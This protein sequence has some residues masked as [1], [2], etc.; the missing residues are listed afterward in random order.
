MLHGESVSKYEELVRDQARK[1]IDAW[2]S[3]KPFPLFPY[4]QS[5]ALEV[6]LHAVVYLDDERDRNELRSLIP[7]ILD[8]GALTELVWIAPWLGRVGPWKRYMETL[9]RTDDL[10]FK[11]I[12]RRR[13]D[14][15]LER[16]EDI[17]SL[18]IRSGEDEARDDRWLR[19]QLM[20]LILAG[21]DTTAS[22]LAWT[23]EL[24]ARAP[25][26]L[27]AARAAAETGDTEY[28]EAVI[29]E[30]LRLRPVVH[31]VARTLKKPVT[32]G[33]YDLPAGIM[34]APA[35][36]LV[37]GSPRWYPAPEEFR[38]ERFIDGSPAPYTWLPF[39]GGV[40]RCP[41]AAFAI[42]EMRIAL[43]EMLLRT[44]LVPASR[45]PER[46]RPRHINTIPGRGGRVVLEWRR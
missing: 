36:G 2:P 43:A 5:L 4:T 12:D 32:V 28:L 26:T 40:R 15:E 9:R 6:I 33:P 22:G 30:A 41:G 11:A 8:V 27:A 34:V 25:R 24:L 38:P 18:L 3:G 1:M 35:I 21:H 37:H 46:P 39:G 42:M 17:L 19:D 10:L 14:P 31:H 44:H 29:S 7:A 20:T 23:I 45:R 16:R 13:R